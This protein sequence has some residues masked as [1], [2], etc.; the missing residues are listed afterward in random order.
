[1]DID[2]EIIDDCTEKPNSSGYL[3]WDCPMEGCI[4]QYRRYY[5]LQNHLDAQKH[6]LKKVKMPL[7][8]KAKIMFKSLLENDN[9]RTPVTLQTFNTIRNIEEK[10]NVIL[11]KGWALSLPRTNTRFTD[12]QKQYLTEV[13][14]KGESSGLK[15]NPGTLSLVI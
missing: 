7:L 15:S 10:C 3:L 5:D 13:Y 1:M 14:D 2:Q 12:A 6:V 8:D 9:H 11:S 4:R